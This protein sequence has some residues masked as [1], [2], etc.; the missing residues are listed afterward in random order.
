MFRKIIRAKNLHG[1]SIAALELV[2]RIGNKDQCPE[3][4]TDLVHVHRVLEDEFVV[5]EGMGWNTK[6]SINRNTQKK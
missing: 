6:T 5:E 3:S 2:H 1:P 4:K